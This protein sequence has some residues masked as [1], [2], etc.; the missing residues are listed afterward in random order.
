M[1]LQDPDGT[2][3]QEGGSSEDGEQ[4]GT[5]QILGCSLVGQAFTME[6]AEKGTR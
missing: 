1:T 4:Q 6:E 2:L 5:R 3:G